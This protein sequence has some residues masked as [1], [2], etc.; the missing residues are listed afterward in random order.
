[1]PPRHFESGG[2]LGYAIACNKEVVLACSK[3]RTTK[4]PFDV[5]HRTIIHYGTSSPSDYEALKKQVTEKMTAYLAKQESLSS[6]VAEIK[7]VTKSDGLEQHEIVALAVITAALDH[8]GDSYSVYA[9]KRDMEASGYTKVATT[10]AL[11]S[12]S[13]QSYISPVERFDSEARESY[14]AYG[15]TDQGWDWVV[16]NQ[17]KFNL[18]RP[19]PNGQDIPF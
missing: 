13:N 18:T 2:L 5:Q 17:S 19:V 14:L 7:K 1:M 16:T 10:I 4:F 8:P 3:E 11:R 12:L 6:S 15:L 9:I